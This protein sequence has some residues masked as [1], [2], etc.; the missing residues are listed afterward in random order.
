MRQ[1][2]GNLFGYNKQNHSL[3]YYG[4]KAEGGEH[5]CRVAGALITVR[6]QDTVVLFSKN[7]SSQPANCSWSW[8][9]HTGHYFSPNFPSCAIDVRDLPFE[10]TKDQ[11]LSLW[12]MIRTGLAPPW[13]THCLVIPWTELQSSIC[14]CTITRRHAHS[15]MH[16]V[17]LHSTVT[18]VHG[19]CMAPP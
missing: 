15:I 3:E 12:S 9:E 19:S 11:P 10:N 8:G 7:P 5:R 14:S 13:Q 17:S 16:Y 18:K 4:I 2:L 1:R 6:R